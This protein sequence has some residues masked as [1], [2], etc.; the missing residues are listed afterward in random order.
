MDRDKFAGFLQS[1]R[2][3]K[4]LT[5]KDLADKLHVTVSAVSKWERG[6]SYPDITMLEPLSEVLDIN[7]T[8]LI[9][10][11]RSNSDLSHYEAS[12][13]IKEIISEERMK[14][15]KK[16]IIMSD[17]LYVVLLFIAIATILCLFVYGKIDF[18]QVQTAFLTVGIV[19]AALFVI[20]NCKHSIYGGKF[21]QH[22]KDKE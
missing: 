11:E 9:K 12:E 22:F 6:L 15:Y 14:Q 7:I 20:K 4:N 21:Q 1:V 10:S 5:Q 13:L 18:G 16:K 8:E 3:E 2:K 19:F 17:I